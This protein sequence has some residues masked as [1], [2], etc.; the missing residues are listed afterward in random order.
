MPFAETRRPSL[1]AEIAVLVSILAVAAF[2][3]FTQLEAVPP[4]MTHDEAAFGAEAEI[5]L[6]GERPIYFALGYGH[7]PVYAYLVAAAFRLF[8]HTLLAIRVTSANESRHPDNQPI[9]PELF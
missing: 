1:W 6:A 8:G 9:L 4:G 3:R 2:L 5:V 7:E